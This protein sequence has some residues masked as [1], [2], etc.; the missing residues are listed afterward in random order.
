MENIKHQLESIKISDP[1]QFQNLTLFAI[2]G[3]NKNSLNYLT[4]S[5]AYEKNYVEINE[6]SEA[7]T[8]SQLLF[9][10]KSDI[11][12]L[13]LEGEELNGAKQNRIINVSILVPGNIGMVI[14][15]SCC[16]RSRWGY[17][18]SRKFDLSN[19]MTFAK[20]RR[21][22]LR[23]VNE[24]WEAGRGARSNQ[25][26]VWSDIGIKF[27]KMNVDSDTESMGD[28]YDSYSHEIEQYVKSFA[29]QDDDKGIIAAI[30]GKIVSIEFFD[31]NSVF[32]NN[33]GKI[34]RSLAADA[35]EDKKTS[36][37]ASLKDAEEFIA[38]VCDSK[39]IEL[40]SLGLGTQYKL[41]AETHLGQ[42]LLFHT[43]LIHFIVFN[44]RDWVQ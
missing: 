12:I 38:K 3:S 32:K 31:K 15:V 27:S 17:K 19:R 40:G 23:R 5:Q 11:P 28:F 20:A 37:T 29:A 30:N 18:S 35:I 21:N 2:K 10:N 9:I 22:K 43:N 16:E 13:I 36:L 34:I 14:P 8:V 26:E 6:T 44:N 42:T 24:S 25:E 39:I 1:L 7:G 4:L 41:N 33:L